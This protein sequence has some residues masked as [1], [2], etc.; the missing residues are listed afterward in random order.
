MSVLPQIRRF[1]VEDFVS[2]KDWIAKLFTPLN[3]FMDGTVNTFNR[4]ITL[5]DNLAADIK[6]VTLDSV[7]SAAIPFPVAWTLKSGPISV[8]VGN[9]I[10]A[11]YSALVL[12]APVYVQWAYDSK[13]F[14][15]TNLI[16]VTPTKTVKTTITLVCFTG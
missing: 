16:G 13:G 11:D 14:R 9:V 3:N 7:P 2:Q 6:I 1:L 15:L 8:H 5:R 4:G 10:N 12:T